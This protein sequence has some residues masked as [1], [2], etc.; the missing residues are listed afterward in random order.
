V[1]ALKSAGYCVIVPDLLGFGKSDKPEDA[2]CYSL[3]NI[4]R[5]LCSV[6][7]Q[8]QVPEVS[9]VGHD[10][11]AAAA[12]TLA[13]QHSRRV[14]RLCVL[15]VGHPGEQQQLGSSSVCGLMATA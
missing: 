1:Q 2:K 5:Q 14:K 11:G 7:D 15:S 10:F 9:V 12:W 13:I 4:A 8:L 6:L 3:R